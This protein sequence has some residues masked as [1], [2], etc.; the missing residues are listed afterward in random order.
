MDARPSKRFRERALGAS[1]PLLG[2]S[3]PLLGAS[4]PLL[5]ASGPR[6]G[7]GGGKCAF[8]VLLV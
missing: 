8:R 5:G 2:A 4:G 3:G 6:P 1:G 7:A